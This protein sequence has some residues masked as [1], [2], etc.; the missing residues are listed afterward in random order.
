MNS[1]L[2]WHVVEAGHQPGDLVLKVSDAQRK[3]SQTIT[4]PVK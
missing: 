1:T 4:I 2:Y 3:L